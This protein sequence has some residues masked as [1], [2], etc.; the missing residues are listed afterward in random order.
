MSQGSII[1]FGYLSTLKSLVCGGENLCDFEAGFIL[2][3]CDPDTGDLRESDAERTRGGLVW[4]EWVL[5]RYVGPQKEM[6]MGELAM[7]ESDLGNGLSEDLILKHLNAGNCFDF[8]YVP[9]PRDEL[10]FWRAETIGAHEPTP[11]KPLRG[12]STEFMEFIF[13]SGQWRVGGNSPFD[14]E[15]KLLHNGTV[16]SL[17]S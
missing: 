5:R 16:R 17:K 12:L 9:Q 11:G 4:F 1:T 6:M 13:R 14:D 8:D 7:P 3:T 10:E 2:C 15:T